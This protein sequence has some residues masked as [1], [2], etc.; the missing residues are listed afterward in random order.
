MLNIIQ[1]AI[2]KFRWYVGDS[3]QFGLFLL[4]LL[5]L[6]LAR[7]EKGRKGLFI[8]YTVVFG[9]IYLCPLTAYII[10]EYCIGELVY[11]RM[12]WILPIPLVIAYVFTR[13]WCRQKKR[14]TQIL[15]LVILMT[16]LVVSGK[17]IYGTETPFVR[18]GNLFKL[19]P[20]VCW[21]GDIL[22]ADQRGDEVIRVAAAGDLVGYLRQYDA[23]IELVYGR[24]VRN[25][26][27]KV[28]AQELGSEEPDFSVVA[29]YARLLKCNFLVYNTDENQDQ[30]V[31]S[32]GY[33]EIG[34]AGIYT[35]YRDTQTEL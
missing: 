8:G 32:I 30:I 15:S 34:K 5:Y 33:Q 12:F 21:V 16:L 27:R 23:G 20:E 13:I 11:W 4:A 2:E 14:I 31:K 29:G 25:R 18:A 35:V 1:S 9:L 17:N 24:R 6:L 10:M 3:W 22:R 7:E 19:P 26:R 28:L